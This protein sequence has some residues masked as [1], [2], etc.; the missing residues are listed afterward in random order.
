MLYD[1][2]HLDELEAYIN[3]GDDKELLKWWAQYCESKGQFDKAMKFY[4]RAGDVLALCRVYCYNHDFASAAELVLESGDTSAAYH[5]ARQHEANGAVSRGCG[6]GCGCECWW[7]CGCRCGCG[8]AWVWGCVGVG[9]W[10]LVAV[11]VGHMR[12]GN[13]LTPNATDVT[14]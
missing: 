14:L 12:P 11:S 7:R 6:C 13:V 2:Q 9:V 5:L 10:V 3:A 1:S 8:C 4:Q